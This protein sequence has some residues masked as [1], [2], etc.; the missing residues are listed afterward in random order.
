MPSSD[1]FRQL[2]VLTERL[3]HRFPAIGTWTIATIVSE[4]HRSFDDRPI[5]DFIP[6][7]VERG[8]ARRLTSAIR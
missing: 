4:I 6:L 1:E 2:D 7:L 3:S 5:R 8:A